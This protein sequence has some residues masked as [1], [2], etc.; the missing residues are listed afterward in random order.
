MDC[1]CFVNKKIFLTGGTGFFGKSILDMLA[2][3]FLSDCSFV[4]LSRNPEKFLQKFPQYGKLEQVRF[5]SGDV[6][7]F[8]FPQENFDYIIH[9]ATPAVTTLAKGEMRSIIIEG[10]SR[11]LEFAKVCGAEKLL[12]VSS[13]AVY[14]PQGSL[15][16]VP[17]DFPCNPV[18]EYGIAKLDAENMCIASGVPTFI[19]RCFAFVGP[20]LDLD[21]HFAI[22]NFIRDAMKKRD[23]IIKGDGTPYRSYM[24]SCDLVKWLFGIL[25][26]GKAGRPYNVGSPHGVTIEE[27][28]RRVADVFPEKP[29][30]K[31][32]TAAAAGAE[33]SR[34][35]PDVS[36]AEKEL[37][38]KIEYSL[39]DAIKY[40]VNALK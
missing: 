1:S 17:E 7:N 32:L 31:V 39:D 28:A 5:V 33:P 35:V 27:T 10:T 8:E 36:R 23:I 24:L 18:T 12:F 37:G 40:T 15:C 19:A 25:A 9:A 38:L 11:V 26:D 30:V 13:G 22:G 3:G 2:E 21:I 14:G 29:R 34:Y 16:N 4:I 20:R 6:R